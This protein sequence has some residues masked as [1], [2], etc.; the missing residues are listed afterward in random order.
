[1]TE[2]R[3][4]GE[5]SVAVEGDAD[6]VVTG[7]GNTVQVF[8]TPPTPA[9]PSPEEVDT[10]VARYARRIT[11]VYGR[12]DLEVLTPLSE[13]EH[14]VVELREVFVT[15]TVR[16]DLPPVELPRELL[17]RLAESGELSDEDSVPPGVDS[18]SLVSLR[19]SYLRRPAQPVLEVLAAPANR[20]LVLLGDPGAGKSTLV[21]YAA[22]ALAGGQAVRPLAA[23][24]G[25]VPLVVEL[26]QYAEEQW[27][28]SGFEDF[29][30]HLHDDYALSV[31]RPV[32]EEL[33]THGRALVVFDGLDELF[34]PIVRARTAQRIG[35]FAAR[36]PSARIVVTSRVI[37]YQRGVLEAA[38]FTHFMLQDLDEDRIRAFIRGWYDVACP[39]APVQAGQLV[40]RL[41][42]AVTG[43]RPLQEMAGNP[44]LLTVLA[45]IGRRQT[46][47]HN[48][49]SVFEHAVTVL[50]SHWDRAAKL[51]K[52]PLSPPVAEALDVLGP[53]ERL[54]LLRLLARTMQEGHSGIAGN[55]IHASDLEQVFREYLQKY[56][57]PPV[58]ATAAARAM[59]AQL[60]ERNF[61]LSRYGGEVYGF[62]HRAFLE[63]LAAADIAQRYNDREWATP[64]D[65]VEQVVVGR[66]SD[67]AWHEVL[68]LLV[69]QI[70]TGTTGTAV[71]R[72]LE[73]NAAAPD[74]DASHVAL[75]LRMLAETNKLGELSARST[76][77]VD[78]ATR[79]LDL[80]GRKGPWL[81]T[82][83]MPALA[84]FS[85]HWAGQRS[86]LRW[87][88][89][90]GQFASSHEP[91]TVAC[92][93]RL[94]VDE[95]SR[96]ARLSYFGGDRLRF[97]HAW[98]RRQ[99]QDATVYAALRQA[100][101][102]DID[103][104]LRSLALEIMAD[105]W[106]GR[107][108][109]RA[110]M[111]ARAEEDPDER[112]RRT[113]LAILARLYAHDRESLELLERTA[114]GNP[115][116]WSR[117]YVVRALGGPAAENPGIRRFLMER[118]VADPD[119]DVRQYAVESLG[120]HC[121]QHE[122]VFELISRLMAEADLTEERE[123]AMWVIGKYWSADSRARALLLEQ[124]NNVTRPYDLVTVLF[125][126]GNLGP[127][128]AEVGQ[129][130]IKA[131]ADPDPAV[132]R[133]SLDTLQGHP[134]VQEELQDLVLRLAASDPD[135]GVRYTAVELIDRDR[136]GHDAA[137]GVL[138]AAADDL[139]GFVRDR[140]H[141]RLAQHWLDDPA[142]QQLLVD[143]VST[144]GTLTA[145]A[146]SSVLRELI[147]HCP[148]RE[149]I[150]PLVL[151][152][153]D[154]PLR[155]EHGLIPDLPKDDRPGQ[156]RQWAALIR[157]ATGPLDGYDRREYAIRTLGRQSVA[158]TDP[159]DALWRAAAE[160]T[161]TG[162]AIVALRTRWAQR[163]DMRDLLIRAARHR[164]DKDARHD[165][166]KALALHQPHHPDVQALFLQLATDDPAADVRFTA[167]CRWALTAA[168]E[169]ALP[170]AAA[171]ATSDSD[172][173]V[174]RRL[175]HMV[176]LAWPTAPETASALLECSGHDPDEE[177]RAA[178]AHLLGRLFD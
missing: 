39:N 40:E 86:F 136:F 27:R 122:E 68:L 62:V 2:A 26:R 94:G 55:H 177:T 58:H 92:A 33:L 169:E 63:Y 141:L 104:R 60:H 142:I 5:R 54:E 139:D 18:T 13:A 70:G 115:V 6:T 125:V 164:D 36:Y 143:A 71:D 16:A 23:L 89:I 171:R 158:R 100:A 3:A 149:D 90:S 19:D 42:S 9:P 96:L 93:L 59:V 72:L 48:R 12:L 159:R 97:L 51:L 66:A 144:P 65:L 64:E 10:A 168:D 148:D 8:R 7:D 99:P 133:A 176:A 153:V 78:A 127:A 69:G 84:T 163:G 46:L 56:E 45:I 73:L 147:R 37:G 44:L 167:L 114:V 75:A 165:A 80:R 154:L 105:V 120:R 146:R 22:L 49:R 108:D 74:A 112:G 35:A 4:R 172:P 106:S 118:A 155:T 173:G 152:A 110:L 151:D 135:A 117:R 43:S 121:S 17:R 32:Q 88:R 132:R 131:A 1:M 41:T 140:V 95:L 31:P 128:D 30:A 130:V 87:F 14:P 34:D 111:R 113:A 61:I 79:A 156:D 25:R 175:L 77:V 50:V 101:E 52:A 166:V 178:A 119:T 161:A 83:A 162:P 81:L 38:G 28:H 102:H 116:S 157:L 107:E 126:L 29:L 53:D 134:V 76:A 150:R 11:Q 82:E 57:L 123:S 91:I 47:P 15:P 103:G 138:T 98:A 124:A 170:V 109:V 24:A 129:A 160:S 145:R 21:R 20:L 174:R 67:P 85:P 137:R